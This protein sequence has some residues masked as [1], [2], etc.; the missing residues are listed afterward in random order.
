M[1][2]RSDIEWTDATWNP[3]RGCSRVSPGCVNCYAEIMAARFS[4]S[5]EELAAP[6]LEAFPGE[7][8]PTFKD[9]WGHGFAEMKGG[10]H[11]WT[12][13][14]ALIESQLDLPSIWRKPMRIFVNST[15]DLFHE[16]LPEDAIDQIFAV[17]A[18]TP[19][20]TFQ[21]LTKRPE[22]MR[23]HVSEAST[24]FR[25]AKAMGVLS[26]AQEMIQWPLP[27]VWLGTSVE[28]QERADERIPHLLATPAAV[29]FLS[30][31]PLLGP[32]DLRAIA[33]TRAEGF[34]RPLD[35]RFNKIGL[36]IV[37]GESGPGA[38][39]MQMEWARSLRDQCIDASV[40]FFMKQI[41]KKMPIPDDLMIRQF[42]RVA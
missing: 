22:R 9:Q 19:R 5:A 31:E 28:D 37:G 38:R 40:P 24:P 8:P 26:V 29:R 30:C 42:P 32:I 10:D 35:G 2:A 1:A 4:K 34:M 15:S 11:R 17:M 20:H 13:K 6:F 39:P 33:R 41:D 21:I 3:I 16:K 23:E 36:V 18:L 27:N 25:V 14:V 7:M 12:G